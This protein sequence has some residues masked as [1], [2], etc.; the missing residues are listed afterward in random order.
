MLD[1]MA[2]SVGMVSASLVY[3]FCSQFFE[4]LVDLIH[5]YRNYPEVGTDV[6]GFFA[7]LYE[8]MASI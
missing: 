7:S 4:P 8:N 5:V 6:I 1:G 2:Q 3:T